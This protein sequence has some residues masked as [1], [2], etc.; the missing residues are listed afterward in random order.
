MI[1][2]AVLG[3]SMPRATKAAAAPDRGGMQ[4][5]FSL[6]ALL[7]TFAAVVGIFAVSPIALEARG[8]AYVDAGGGFFSKFHPATPIALTAFLM[9]CLASRRPVHLAWRLTTGDEGVL[10]LLAGTIVAAVFAAVV[11]KTPVTPLVDTFILPGLIFVLLRDLDRRT[12]SLLA[13]LVA[14]VLVANAGLAIVEFVHGGHFIQVEAPA[15]VTNDPTK[16]NAV[17]SWKAEMAMDWRAEALLGHPL[18]NGLVVGSFLLCLAAPGADWIP[19]LLRVP[20]IGLQLVAMLCFG[21]RTAM[22]LS[23]LAVGWFVAVQVTAAIER[24]TR[25]HPR[26]AALVVL[27]AG[28]V[29]AA[30][31]LL[32]YSGLLDRTLERFGNDA[33]SATT[34][35]TMFSLFGPISYH[36]LFLHPDK[37]LVATLQRVYGLEFGIESSWLGMALTYGII[38]TAIVTAGILAFLRSVLRACGRG[39]LIVSLFYLAL[40]S[41]SASLSGKTTTFA[42]VVALIVLFLRKD[43]AVPARH[44]AFRVSTVHGSA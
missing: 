8:I 2:D 7:A 19:L 40:V 38:V 36:D 32:A 22:V 37:D 29:A 11:D 42:M 39:A 10:L 12:A 43:G 24:G 14:L 27:A 17:F 41:V 21:A 1:S 26:Q 13:A 35:V 9:R 28:I 4:E 5:T 20:L 3:G 34:R 23:F 6:L 15:G 18:V 30:V 33:G 16:A 31:L 44:G 25:F